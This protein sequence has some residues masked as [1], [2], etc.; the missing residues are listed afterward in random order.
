MAKWFTEAWS[1]GVRF[2]VKYARKEY[3]E[4][5]PHQKIAF[6]ES[7]ELGRFFTL[8][9][10]MMACE[11]DE[12]VYHE[13]MIHVP[14]SVRPDICR[15]LVIGGGD[16]GSVRELLRYP[17]IA[18][19]TLVEID[20]RVV[21]LCERYFPQTSR[22]LRDARVSLV[23]A[24]GAAFVAN[25]VD[26]YDLIVV[27]STDPIGPGEGLFSAAFYRDCHRILAS[28]G[29]LVNQHES[30]YFAAT[31]REMIRAHEKIASLFPVARVYQ[32]FIPTYPSGHWLFGFASK[33]LDPVADFRAGVQDAAD[34]RT[35]YYNGEVHRAAFALPNDV[36]EAL[37]PKSK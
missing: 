12:Y 20:E 37:A 24:D 28:D 27:D 14:M 23:Y 3:A 15:V 34:I 26:A 4:R 33:R 7:D 1:A 6:Y 21:T 29:I 30:P 17:Q 10:V 32:A 36:R 13:M 22:G 19:I 11:K 8:D 16:G 18:A 9:G 35:R 31:R 25:A 2:S 5:T